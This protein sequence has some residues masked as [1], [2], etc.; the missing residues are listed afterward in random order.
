VSIMRVRRNR[1]RF[2][3]AYNFS[4]AETL[5]AILGILQEKGIRLVVAQ[6]LEDVR[7]RGRY[8]LEQLFGEDA[9]CA[10]LQDVV[11]D[12]QKRKAEEAK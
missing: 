3:G 10:T 7:E 11:K 5:R 12:Y 4:A 6:V 1:R 9:F 8:H 2:V